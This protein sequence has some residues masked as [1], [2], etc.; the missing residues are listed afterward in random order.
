MSEIIEKAQRVYDLLS[1]DEACSGQARAAAKLLERLKSGRINI[2]VIGQ[3]KRGKSSL[4]NRILEHELFPVGIVPITSAVTKVVYG[5]SKKCEVLFKNGIRKE[6]DAAQLPEYVSEQQNSNNELG[7]E[8]VLMQA[9]SDFLKS[10]ITFV[11]TPGVGSFHQNNTKTAYD[12]LKESDGVIFLLSV[13][14][15]IN[16][17]EIE[18]LKNTGEYVGK[19]YFAV[20]KTD[21]VAEADLKA[22]TDYCNQLICQLTGAESIRIFPVSAKTGEGVEALKTAILSDYEKISEKIMEESGRKKLRDIIAQTT[23]QLRFYWK[24]M[25]MR[26]EDLDDRFAQIKEFID[27]QKEYARQQKFGFEVHLNIIRINLSE[28]VDEL[29]GMEYSYD[30]DELPAGI[31]QMGYEEFIEKVDRLCDD[32]YETLNSILLYREENAYTVAHRINQINRLTWWLYEI[33]DSISEEGK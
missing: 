15:P 18:F 10:G 28:K 25:N 1:K 5:D 31:S 26:M 6:I 17:I 22:Y 23:S 30:I 13:D 4:S 19:F 20:N 9:P 33:R 16:Q 8:E 14:S 27:T 3:F 21:T 7:V 24:A 12:Y 29:F 11:D 2:S 32:L